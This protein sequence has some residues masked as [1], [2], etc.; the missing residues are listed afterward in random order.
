MLGVR[1]EEAMSKNY[2][3]NRVIHNMEDDCLSDF[4]AGCCA[5]GHFQR[6]FAQNIDLRLAIS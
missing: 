2:P 1:G 5:E 6:H 3:R 4:I